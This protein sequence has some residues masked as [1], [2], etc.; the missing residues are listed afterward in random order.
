MKYLFP[1]CLLFVI[2]S[3]DHTHRSEYH[4]DNNHADTVILDYYN[5][6]IL[7]KDTFPPGSHIEFYTTSTIGGRKAKGDERTTDQLSLD[8]VSSSTNT[9]MLT[10]SYW[11]YT[12]D[13]KYINIYTFVVDET[14]VQ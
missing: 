10:E 1:I 5:A 3:C 13:G 12:N 8:A 6:G 4:V 11:S 14:I 2:V 9:T 7:E